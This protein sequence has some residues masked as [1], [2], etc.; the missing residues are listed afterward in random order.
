MKALRFA[1]VLAGMAVVL[2]AAPAFASIFTLYYCNTPNMGPREY[3]F[4]LQLDN[5]DGTWTPGYGI[6]WIVFG[7]AF[8]QASPIQDFVGDS[9]SFPV[10]PWTE[11]GVTG[12]GDHNGINLAPVSNPTP[13][14]AP[15]YWVPAA[16]G[17]TITWPRLLVR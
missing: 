10:G 2:A 12:N 11:F 8:Q 1:A 7:D 3:T 15:V 17:D 5:H 9:S 13:P 6:G 4:T 16:I 14:Y